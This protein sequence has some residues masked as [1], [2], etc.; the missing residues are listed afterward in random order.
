MQGMQFRAA[1]IVAL[2]IIVAV[3]TST[4]GTCAPGVMQSRQMASCMGNGQACLSSAAATDCCTQLEPRLAVAKV[5]VSKSSVRSVVHW[6]TPITPVTLVSAT[7][8]IFNTGSLPDLIAT[9]GPPR[10]I[11]FGTFL[12]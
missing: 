9:F 4:A 12:I 10:Y 6:F 3:V 2:W 1:G 5:D 7:S 11:T 8:T